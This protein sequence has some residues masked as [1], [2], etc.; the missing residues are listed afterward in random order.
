MSGKRRDDAAPQ[1]RPPDLPAKLDDLPSITEGEPLEESRVAGLDL[2]GSKLS[3]LSAKSSV[4]ESVSFT[5]CQIPSPR[6]R[7]VRFI[8]CDLSNATLRGV[9]ATRVE[10]V[11]CRLTGMIAIECRW[12]DVL[13][14]N[15]DGRYLQLNG[16]RFRSCEFKHSNFSDA[17]FRDSDLEGA[18]FT[19]TALNRADLS[20]SRLKG[21]DLRGA[22]IGGIVIGPEAVRGAIVSPTQAMDLARLLGLVIK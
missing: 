20:H 17:D 9:E 8:K 15:C 10:F 18:I 13:V 21:A 12:Q 16:G 2:S 5:G 4:F 22:E 1:R 19:R 14:E 6:F 3:G 11:D 7:D